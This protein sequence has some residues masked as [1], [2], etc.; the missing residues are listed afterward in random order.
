MDAILIGETVN[1]VNSK[2]ISNISKDS[3]TCWTRLWLIFKRL[4]VM[5][6]LVKE[7]CRWPS[8]K[9]LNEEMLAYH[10]KFWEQ[11]M[12]IKNIDARCSWGK[13]HSSGLFRNSVP[14]KCAMVIMELWQIQRCWNERKMGYRKTL[15]SVL[16][17]FRSISP[18]TNLCQE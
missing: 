3:Q 15:E 16:S 1:Q 13:I 9:R 12:G 17:L 14:A 2:S 4:L 6:H 7:H 10:H 18:R 11:A 8:S 5:T